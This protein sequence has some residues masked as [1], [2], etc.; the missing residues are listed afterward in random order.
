MSSTPKRP[1]RI[2]RRISCEII[3]R[4]GLP[5]RVVEIVAHADERFDGSGVP[6]GL[7][8]EE[9]PLASRILAAAT[10]YVAM[11]TPGI[12]A[13]RDLLPPDRAVAILR[14]RAGRVYDPQVVAA[15]GE[16]TK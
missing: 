12:R 3:Q 2:D 8:G 13:D 16:L 10:A 5:N 11:S 6:D 1:S 9:I 4:L 7:A 15:L 14:R